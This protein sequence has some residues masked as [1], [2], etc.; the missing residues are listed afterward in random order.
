MNNRPKALDLFCGAGGL[1]LGFEEAGFDIIAGIDVDSIHLSTYSKNFPNAITICKDISKLTGRNIFNI[2]GNG[3]T[4]IDVLFGGPPCQGFS[5]IGSRRSN[6]PHNNLLLEF[7]RLVVE[8]NPLCF[9]LENVTG[10]TYGYG[11]NFLNLFRSIIQLS[12]YKFTLPIKHLNAK[13]FGIPQ[14]RK[15]IFIFGV[16][17][18]IKIVDYPSLDSSFYTVYSQSPTVWD[19]IGDLND[20]KTKPNCDV[21]RG[22]LG[23]PSTYSMNLRKKNKHEKNGN[24]DLT[25]CTISK[26]HDSVIR[27]FKATLPGQYEPISRY[28]KL[29][30]EGISST[31]R[32]GSGPTSG[33]YTAPRP[34]HP[35]HPRCITV[36][37]AAR[38][39]SFPDWFQFDKT[40]WHGFRQVGNSVP[41]LLARNVALSVMYTL[42]AN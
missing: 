25:G 18:D 12:G 2:I 3:N 26:H 27:R 40:I 7:A 10:L 17:N 14:N 1:S 39:Q 11:Q 4:K 42:K 19:A 22:A 9:V 30:K 35:M 41:P 24:S 23:K 32:A 20:I 37:E 28:H 6:D 38:L 16:K 21:Y 15:R 36:R 8:L 34:I 31:I 33:S 5:M 13:N 29:S